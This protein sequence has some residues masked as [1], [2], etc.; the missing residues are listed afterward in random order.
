MSRSPLVRRAFLKRLG[1][2]VAAGTALG[3]LTACRVRHE[4]EIATVAPDPTDPNPFAGLRSAYG[5]ARGLSYFNHA[6]IGCMPNAVV[7]ARADYSRIC[8][9]NPWLYMWGGEWDEPKEVSRRKCAAFLDCDPRDL[10][11]VHNTTEAFNI[12]AHG[13]DLGPK[14]EVLMSS[15]THIGAKRTWED[16]AA[17]R[18]FRIRSFE[19]P[20]ARGLELTAEEL[21]GVHAD[22]V[23]DDTRVMVLT[24]VD[25]I[26]GIRIPLPEIAKAV[27]RRGVD[28][29]AVDGAQG[30]GLVPLRLRELDV[31]VYATS[32]H[33]WMQTPKGMGLMYVRRST[34]GR[35]SPMVTTW[36][37]R[38]WGEDARRY[39]DY[40]TRNLPEVMTL[41]HAVDFQVQLGP[42]A[43]AKRRAELRAHARARVDADPQLVWHSPPPGPLATGIYGIGAKGTFD[44]RAAAKRLFEDHRIVVR[45]FDRDEIHCLRVSPNVI[46]DEADLDRFIDALRSILT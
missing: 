4:R 12:V 17:R 15:I 43:V 36:G 35:I 8:E 2:G 45:G 3:S 33:K 20:I 30:A 41:G 24:D 39:E 42:V 37:Q 13:M 19:F 16:L 25:N 9:S 7:E 11:L 27:R 26:V 22:A 29:I 34:Q 46:D 40:G 6:S 32:T 10:A 28:V 31:D 5:L 21:V 44:G 23:R 38:E 14:D 18:G 1:G